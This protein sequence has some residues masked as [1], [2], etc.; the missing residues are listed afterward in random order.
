MRRNKGPLV[1]IIVI[2]MILVVAVVALLLYK[3][4]FNK[5]DK[6]PQTP[7]TGLEQPVEPPVEEPT[8]NIGDYIAYTPDKAQ[9]YVVDGTTAGVANNSPDGVKQEELNWRVLNINED[10]TIDIISDEPMS[11]EVYF[12][13]ALG[14][15][16]GVYL[17]NEICEKLYSNKS[18]G[19]VA[20]SVKLEDI[21]GNMSEEGLTARDEYVT[22][23]VAYG[24]SIK[25]KNVFIPEIYTKIDVDEESEE[26]YTSPTKST[27]VSQSEVSIKHTFYELE[28]IESSY[29]EDENVYEMLFNTKT[30]YWVGTRC[31]D[32]S[33]EHALFGLRAISENTITGTAFCSSNSKNGASRNHIR[34]VVTLGKNVEISAEGGTKSD[35]KTVTKAGATGENEDLK[36]DADKEIIYDAEYTYQNLEEEK[37]TSS[38]T[39]ETYSLK[40]I[41]VPVI[42]INSS[43]A[44]KANNEIKEIFNELA[45]RFKEELDGAQISYGIAGYRYYIDSEI[46]SV[47][48]KTEKGGTSVPVY[49]YYAYNF[50]LNNGSQFTYKEAYEF[51][52]FTSS[53]INEK[54]ENAITE[55]LKERMKGFEQIGNNNNNGNNN[56]LENMDIDTYNKASIQ[57]YRD[58]VNDES[59]KYFIDENE[60]L[61]V[62]VDLEIP[63]DRGTFAV[64]ITIE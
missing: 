6:K 38:S 51:A 26:N 37:Y 47:E 8:V 49:E 54:V 10:G 24:D 19:A 42:N 5:A 43:Y 48:I 32:C 34:P 16:N 55:T 56:D 46:L 31:T 12:G 44:T 35:P 4:V 39:Q 53:N 27:Y 57:N 25:H 28:E 40:D 64:T 13:G 11:Q 60:K 50:N 23:D 30:G 18:L 14:Y 29:F 9:N 58:S 20:R 3:F 61:N 59:I 63:V 17:L 2:I 36:V 45:K 62:I 1:A 7:Q 41:K 21:E 15:N 22:D 52:G 33:S